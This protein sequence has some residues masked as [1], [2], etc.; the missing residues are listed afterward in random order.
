MPGADAAPHARPIE[1]FPWHAPRWAALT[2]DLARLPHALLLHGPAGLG[3]E[4]FARRLAAG[5]L[6]ERPVEELAP[7]GRCHGCRLFAAG[8]HPDLTW[9]AP[10]EDRR[11]IVI[12]QIRALGAW[13]ALTPHTAARKLA[14]VTPA[15]GMNLNAANSLLKI[16][17]EPPLGS[18]LLLVAHQ[19]GRLPATVRSR[20]HKVAFAAPEH[21]TAQAWLEGQAGPSTGLL[22]RLTGGA[23]LAALALAR[24]GFRATRTALLKDLDDLRTGRADPVSCATRWKG[25]GTKLSLAWLA[26]F[27]A[28]LI[29]CRIAGGGVDGIANPEA[30]IFLNSNKNI[31]NL[32]ELFTYL[33]VVS[34]AVNSLKTG[35]LD[36]QL[37]LEDILIRWCYMSEGVR[38]QPK[39]K[40]AI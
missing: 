20:C 10:E 13:F 38:T 37:L 28:D 33:D 23:P 7:C 2:G 30:E 22:L 11:G 29:R 34:E 21:G 31:L 9:V 27:V 18:V 39:N 24:A 1:I 17:E 14:V 40:A 35:A 19:P 36:E 12:D 4:A 6:C 3:K 26:G 32:N 8:T 15:E 25:T 5:L 16:L